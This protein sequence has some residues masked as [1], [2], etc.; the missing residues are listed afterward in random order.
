MKSYEKLTKF[1]LII[2]D[3]YLASE[4]FIAFQTGSN[5]N[6]SMKLVLDNGIFFE[7]IPFNSDNFDADGNLKS[8]PK[9]LLINEVENNIEYAIL[10]STCSGAWR[11]LIGDTIKFTNADECEIII[12]GRTKHFLSMCG[13]HLS[14]DNMN[15]ALVLAAKDLNI[16]VGEYTVCGVPYEGLFAH[17]WYIA[18]DDKVDN[19]IFKSKI[20]EHLKV[21]NDDYRVERGHALKDIFVDVYS[22]DFF[23]EFMKQKGKL[24]SQ[25]K[26]PRVLKG[27]MLEDWQEYLKKHKH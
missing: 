7:F 13:E 4:G 16:E 22:H 11:Y 2:L 10:I 18:T 1:P 19:Q 14:V 15:K 23:M 21:L 20:D 26:F 9:T 3:T 25:H 17:H 24:G 27:K 6:G 5:T 8:D 12:T